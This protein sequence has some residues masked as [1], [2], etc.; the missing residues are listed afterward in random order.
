M[1][2]QQ[3]AIENGWKRPPQKVFPQEQHFLGSRP[4]WDN[5]L[6]GWSGLVW[7]A[8]L[9]GGAERQTT[10]V[11]HLLLKMKLEYVFLTESELGARGFY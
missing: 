9:V 11:T 3:T 6:V 5:G 1:E 8:G 7:W 10:T 2:K 4:F